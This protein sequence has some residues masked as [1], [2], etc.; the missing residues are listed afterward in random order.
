M[1]L[2]VLAL[3]ALDAA[4]VDYWD[5]DELRL[6]RSTEMETFSGMREN[7]PYTP[8]VW[9]TVAT[10]LQPEDHGVTKDGTSEWSNPLVEFASKFTGNLPLSVRGSLG[11]IAED[12]IGAS[13]ELGKTDAPTFYDGDGRVVHTWPGAGPSGDVVAIWNMMKPGEGRS[14]EDFE[15]EVLGIGAQQF[16]WIEEML[17]HNLVL[18]GTHVHTLDVFGHAYPFEQDEDRYEMMY[19]WVANWVT[20]IR[21]QLGEDDDL[22]VLSDHGMNVEY[23]DVDD[24]RGREGPGTHSFRAFASTT[25]S[26]D[27]PES[28][29]DVKGWVERHVESYSPSD[30]REVDIPEERL[31]ELGYID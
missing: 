1:T 16:G 28:V 15:R 20:R 12:T 2:V 22:L 27:P 24:S 11:D 6:N 21:D 8:E 18:A 23:C 13:Y 10:G 26:D 31:R 30:R 9:A 14:Y 19:E 3:D 4:L 5:V 25:A 7:E 17:R 29:F